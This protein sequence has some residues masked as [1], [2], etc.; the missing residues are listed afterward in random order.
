[1]LADVIY[2]SFLAGIAIGT[3]ALVIK[4]VRALP[5]LKLAESPRDQA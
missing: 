5:T 3:L 4:Q 2:L 1:M